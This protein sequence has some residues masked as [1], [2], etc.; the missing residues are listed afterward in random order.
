MTLSILHTIRSV[1][2][3]RTW[4]PGA[5]TVLAV[6]LCFAALAAG[7]VAV[8]TAGAAEMSAVAEAPIS[9]ALAL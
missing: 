2:P 4:S 7:S 3:I 5:Q 1:P 8:A 6:V 9:L